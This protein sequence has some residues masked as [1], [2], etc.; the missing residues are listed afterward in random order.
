M[1]DS[2]IW[3]GFDVHKDSITAATLEG[4]A[5]RA[6]VARLSGD[7]QKVR[8]F[9]RRLGR[10]GPVR[11]CYEASGAGYVLHRRLTAD[12]FHCDVIA[13]SLIPRRPGDRRKTDR[14][15]A[16][17][18]ARLYR[19][20]HLTTVR[21]PDEDQEEIRTLLRLRLAH[22]R[23]VKRVKHRIQGMLLYR[24][25]RYD[26]TRSYWTQ[27]HRIWL[28]RLRGELDGVF[29][30]CLATE[31]QHL[32]FEEQQVSAMDDE[33]ERL[34]RCAP[35][36]ETVEALMCL[37]G[38]KTLTAMTLAVEIGDIRRFSS[39]RELMAWSGLIPSERS[40]G[41]VQRRGPITKAGNSHV[42]R[43]L[44][45]AAWNNR[46]QAR[47][48]LIL[49]RRR[50][51]QPAPV[52]AIAIKAQ[53]RLSKRLFRLRQRKHTNV[54]IAAVARELCGFVWAIMH[55]APQPQG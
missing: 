22:Q 49:N 25:L 29:G 18:L 2:T 9:V 40:S 45:E 50:Q 47:A 30:Q 39:P 38:V 51:G 3:V 53:A 23:E 28:E 46:H 27:K 11:V 14:L 36:R 12:G 41:D 32:E 5:E 20:G 35:Y 10:R 1:R 48:N 19:S 7:L 44:V 54:A 55:A 26:E 4:D 17:A 6:D 31:L 33:L 37:R 43:L 34:S 42:R 16:V 52:V 15:D 24:G 8:R 13:P 21:V